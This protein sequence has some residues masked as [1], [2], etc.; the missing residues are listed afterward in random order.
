MDNNYGTSLKADYSQKVNIGTSYTAPSWGWIMCKG[1]SN[2]TGTGY[3]INDQLVCCGQDTGVSPT[4]VIIQIIVA[5]GDEFKDISVS[6]ALRMFV[7][8][9]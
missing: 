8:F 5:P 9:D 1:M 4:S 3:Y 6:S 7:P 2:N